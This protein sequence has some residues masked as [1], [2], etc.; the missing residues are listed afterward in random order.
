[1]KPRPFP[2]ILKNIIHTALKSC[3]GVRFH[4]GSICS[5]CGGT[6]SG[7]DARKKRFAILLEDD[8][9]RP[10][11]V[12]IQR[13][14]CCTCGKFAVPREPFYPCTRIGSPVVDL[15]RSVSVAMPF[16]RTSTNLSMMGV[17]VDRW[18][19][20]NYARMPLK[21][22]PSLEVFGMNIPASIISLS[23][24]SESQDHAGHTN[25]EDILAACFYPS[26]RPFR[27]SFPS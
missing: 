27:K 10:V 7:Y 23:S 21:D 4:P 8:Q 24:L 26:D 2:P 13:S 3:E 25:G 11:H 20:R 16:S 18:S 14:Y 5:A 1:M 6:L 12:I 9:P 15:C 19:V 22:V 17:L